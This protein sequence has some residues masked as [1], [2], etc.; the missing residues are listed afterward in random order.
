[1]S[2]KKSS[3]I[4]G[5]SDRLFNNVLQYHGVRGDLYRWEGYDDL[6]QLYKI[7]QVFSPEPWGEIVDRMGQTSYPF[8]IHVRRPWQV[9][10]TATDLETACEQ[11]VQQIVSENPGPYN[12]YWSG[13]IDSTLVLVSFMKL[14]PLS[15]LRVY[16]SGASIAENT[17]LYEKYIKP[18]LEIVDSLTSI[19]ESGVII[20]GDCGD[21][22]WAVIDEDFIFG[23]EVG[24]YIYR[25][26]QEWFRYRNPDEN[27]LAFAEGVMAQAGRP[28]DTLLEARWWFYMLYK[29][30][31]K[32]VS[33]AFLNPKVK[34]VNFYE[35]TRLESWAW[36]NLDKIIRGSDWSSYKW[37]AKEIIYKFDHNRDYLNTKTKELSGDVNRNGTHGR[38]RR[39]ISLFET[40]TNEAPVLCTEPFWSDKVYEQQFGLQYHHLFV[41]TIKP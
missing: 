31:S 40:D 9:D 12:I 25:P 23:S 17:W 14:V 7:N 15:S 1:M 27:F 30:Q 21:T 35:S 38:L 29:S 22:V 41:P 4:Q 20:T 5:F 36:H 16:C 8:Q 13:G 10:P 32:A 2:P 34:I 24:Q 3:G 28:I 19:P 37:P 18:N 26:W 11:E 6:A 33:K 39:V